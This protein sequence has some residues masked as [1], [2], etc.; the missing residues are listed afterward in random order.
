MMSESKKH[1]HRSKDRDVK[2]HRLGGRGREE[3][4]GN[5]GGRGREHNKEAES[6]N[7]VNLP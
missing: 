4:V 7:T 5:A 2:T 6:E 3:E 1:M